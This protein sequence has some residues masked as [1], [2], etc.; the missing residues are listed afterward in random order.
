M[1]LQGTL[2]GGVFVLIFLYQPFKSPGFNKNNKNDQRKPGNKGKKSCI[3][4]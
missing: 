3:E 1:L 4:S 2:M